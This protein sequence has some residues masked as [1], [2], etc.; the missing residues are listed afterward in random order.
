MLRS[1]SDGQL[2]VDVQERGNQGSRSFHSMPPHHGLLTRG[3]SLHQEM[4]VLGAH[5]LHQVVVCRVH[6]SVSLLECSTEGACNPVL[7]VLGTAA[8]S[9]WYTSSSET[10]VLSDSD[11]CSG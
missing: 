11:S 9:A 7:T 10:L 6:C 4:T 1:A 5:Q 3:R 8:L 2:S